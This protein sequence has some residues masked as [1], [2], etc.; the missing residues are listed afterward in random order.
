MEKPK[1]SKT[2]CLETVKRMIEDAQYDKKRARSPKRKREVEAALRFWTS[3][4]YYLLQ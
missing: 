1:L 2:E 3:L 4:E